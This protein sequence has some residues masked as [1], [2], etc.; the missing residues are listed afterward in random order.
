MPLYSKVAVQQYGEDPDSTA[1]ASLGDL[2]HESKRLTS[3][4]KQ[5]VLK[6]SSLLYNS[7]KQVRT[8]GAGVACMRRRAAARAPQVLPGAD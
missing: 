8:Q 6:D 1:E 4:E 5:E 7:P 2:R 3:A